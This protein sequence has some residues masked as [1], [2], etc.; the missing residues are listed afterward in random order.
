MS[1]ITQTQKTLHLDW[2][3]G[4]NP[5]AI[6]NQEAEGQQEL[7]KASQLPARINSPSSSLDA[8]ECYEK[9]GIHVHPFSD[10]IARIFKKQVKKINDD[11]LFLTVILPEGWQIKAS[12]HSM[13]NHLIDDQGRIRAK[14]FYKAAFYD[15]DAFTNLICRYKTDVEFISA[16]PQTPKNDLAIV[17]DNAT[18]QRLFQSAPIDVYS[19]DGKRIRQQAK[20]FLEKNFSNHADFTAYW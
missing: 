20:D 18:G 7:I 3:L 11:P 2:V 6:E 13:W 5:R 15:R 12:T 8:W 16:N 17:V 9:M 14:I 19:E 1:K 4:G 10:K